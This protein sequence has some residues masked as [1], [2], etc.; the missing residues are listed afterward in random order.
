MSWSYNPGLEKPLDQVRFLVGDTKIAK[1]LVQDEEINWALKQEHNI[2]MAA[3]SV[4]DKLATESRG[5][6]SRT[7]GSLSRTFGPE[8]WT[9][10]ASDLRKRGSTHQVLSAGGLSISGKEVQELDS[11]AVQ[12]AIKRGMHDNE[13]D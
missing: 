2:Y 4:A 13:L 11:D 8:F 5:L 10:R 6:R 3:A 9:A 1:Q 12:P 7:T